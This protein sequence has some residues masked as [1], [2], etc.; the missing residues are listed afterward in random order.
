[1]GV[2]EDLCER[3]GGREVPEWY[4]SLPSD[5][6]KS[7]PQEGYVRRDKE[8]ELDARYYWLEKATELLTQPKPDKGMIRTAIEGN[9]VGNPKMAERLR[10]RLRLLR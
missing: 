1:M 6:Y 8:K 5:F 10:E 9:R 3:F 7:Y 2:I 4:L